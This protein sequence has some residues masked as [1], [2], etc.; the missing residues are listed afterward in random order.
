MPL[1]AA[2]QVCSGR[3]DTLSSTF[4]SIHFHWF[5]SSMDND[6][7]HYISSAVSGC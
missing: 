6:Y 5:S 7:R 4:S 1:F 3:F 2:I